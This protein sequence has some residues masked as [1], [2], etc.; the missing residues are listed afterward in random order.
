VPP[1]SVSVINVAACSNQEDHLRQ[2]AVGVL[3]LEAEECTISLCNRVRAA[4]FRL[5]FSHI[6]GT[7]SHAYYSGVSVPSSQ[8]RPSNNEGTA[9]E[10]R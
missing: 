10:Y 5:K 7:F 4:S 3:A 8:Q 6:L 1:S 9:S 2:Y